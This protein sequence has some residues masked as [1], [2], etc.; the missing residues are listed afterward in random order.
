[1]PT[2]QL[3]GGKA[4]VLIGGKSQ[5]VVLTSAGANTL[6]GKLDRAASGKVTSVVT[7]TVEGKSAQARFT[8]TYP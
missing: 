2:A 3:A 4:T 1:V 8:T 7:L 5:T 6:T